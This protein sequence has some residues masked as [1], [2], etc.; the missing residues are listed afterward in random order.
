MEIWIG[1]AV[2]AAFLAQIAV[3]AAL[4]QMKRARVQKKTTAAPFAPAKGTD[5]TLFDGKRYFFERAMKTPPL[6]ALYGEVPTLGMN[7]FSSDAI[8]CGLDEIGV[9]LDRIDPAEGSCF[10]V[11]TDGKTGRTVQFHCDA[12]DRIEA[13]ILGPEL[14][15]PWTGRLVF[16]KDMKAFL[17][18]Y[19]AGYEVIKGFTMKPV[20]T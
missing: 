14:D 8:P 6:Y 11:V 2:V 5:G 10:V 7:I 1:V 20:E 17:T 3:V 4:V 16:P 12:P 9:L 18:D 19:F 13:E 15:G